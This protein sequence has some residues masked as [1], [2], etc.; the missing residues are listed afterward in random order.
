MSFSLVCDCKDTETQGVV[1]EMQQEE[2][3]YHCLRN[4]YND[5]LRE[6]QMTHH[7]DTDRYHDSSLCSCSTGC[8][9]E[10]VLGALVVVLLVLLVYRR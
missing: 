7:T 5:A 9:L 8:R 3:F 6:Y 2:V 10:H 4:S 1:V